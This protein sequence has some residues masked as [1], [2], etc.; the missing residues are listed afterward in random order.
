MGGNTLQATLSTYAGRTNLTDRLKD[1]RATYR[2]D[3]K[4]FPL[5]GSMR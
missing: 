3:S 4:R 5:N 2:S 1:F